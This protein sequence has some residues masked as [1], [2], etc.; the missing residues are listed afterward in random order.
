MKVILLQDVED[1][2]KK[3][4]VKELKDG[5]ARNFLIPKQF[6]KPA[7][8]QNMQWLLRQKETMENEAEEDLKKAQEMASQLDGMEVTITVKVGPE[9]QLF[10]AINSQKVADKLKSMGVPVKKTEIDLKEPLKELG[11]FPLR[12]T[13]SHNLEAEITLI[14]EKEEEGGEETL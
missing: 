2:G 7:T 10:E 9:G 13:L 4:E 8:K 3:Y 1:V 12:V 11:E 6:A 14:I 5:Y